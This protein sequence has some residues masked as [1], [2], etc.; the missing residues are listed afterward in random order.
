MAKKNENVLTEGFLAELYNAA[1]TDSYICSVVVSYMADEYLPDQQYQ[2]LT[3]MLRDYYREYK[4]APKYGVVE[5]MVSRSRSVSELV[6]EIRESSTDADKDSLRD[7]F[8]SYLKLV[9]FKRMYKEIGKMYEDGEGMKAILTMQKEAKN[10]SS[11]TLKPDDFVDVAGTFDERLRDNKER[12]NDETRHK[13]VNAFY[14]D[15]LDELNQGRD[16]RQQ[17]SVFFAMSGVGKSH[18]IRWEGMNCAYVGGY[19]VLHIQLEGAESET[20][21]AYQ[22]G[23]IGAQAFAFEHG[24]IGQH[25]IDQFHK[26]LEAY[27]GTL[28]VKAYPKF[29]K[30]IST[31]DVRN[32]CEKY[33]EK[34][35]FYPDVVLVDSIDLL[36]DSSGKSWDNKSLRFKRIAVAND[37]KDLAGELDAWVCASYQATIED[38]KI[39]D[40]EDF[41]LNGYN[42]SEA[43]GLQRP[44][45]HLIS[46]NQSRKEYKENTMRLY[47][48]KSRFF[49]KA[50]PIKIVTDFEHEVFYN[51][52]ATMNLNAANGK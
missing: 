22:A 35:G 7:Q 3:A 34:Y 30:E 44:C 26:Q 1:I 21:D 37:L 4:A 25:Q 49:R 20:L 50:E 17:L 32:D 33:K 14:I 48:A 41:V 16:L 19:N 6:N 43:K 47:V 29:G 2:Q 11:F 42:L 18:L 27:A 40:D 31:I 28:K 39:V 38:Q 5:Q 51:R 10:L 24:K 13:P 45:T 46:L 36:T 15:G 9:R 12:Y 8:E 23:L 52:Q